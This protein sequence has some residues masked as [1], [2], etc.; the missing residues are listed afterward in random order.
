MVYNPQKNRYNIGSDSLAKKIASLT[1]LNLDEFSK[2][3][4]F[5]G[6]ADCKGGGSAPLFLTVSKCENFDPF[7]A[8]K[9]DSLILKTHFINC[10]EAPE[11][12]F[13]VLYSSTISLSDRFVTGE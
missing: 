4:K 12:I 11:C 8:L 13:H 6:Q 7:F 9:F 2:K 5:Y 1:M 10:E 3:R